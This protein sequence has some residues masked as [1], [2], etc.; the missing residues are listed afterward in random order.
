MSARVAACRKPVPS[1]DLGRRPLTVYL[2]AAASAAD[3]REI[4]GGY[5]F[6]AFG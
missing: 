5:L 3:P 6:S 4:R 2:K 1:N